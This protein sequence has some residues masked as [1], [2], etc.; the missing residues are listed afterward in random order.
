MP[1]VRISA[2]VGFQCLRVRRNRGHG[3]FQLVAGVPN[4]LL[5][6]IDRFLH[7]LHGAANQQY[8]QSAEQKAGASAHDKRDFEQH[9]G[10]FV[11]HAHI[12][13]YDQRAIA[14]FLLPVGLQPYLPLFPGLPF[15]GICQRLHRFIVV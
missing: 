15:D 13:G 2:Q 9:P 14:A 12:H 4:E 3:C 10:V 5:L 1:E 7:W 8:C 6:L 11:F